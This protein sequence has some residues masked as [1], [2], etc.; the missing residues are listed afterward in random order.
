MQKYKLKL[1]KN[2]IKFLVKNEKLSSLFYKQILVLIENPFN[3]NL[4]IK[5]LKWYKNKYRLR[6]WK[7]RF[8]YEI[9][10]DELIVY[11]FDAGNRW[12]IYKN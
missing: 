5:I 12:D 2:V 1:S 7:F 4:D 3:N 6:I 8:L 11:F 9:Y 10:N